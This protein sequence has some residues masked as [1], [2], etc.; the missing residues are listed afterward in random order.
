MELDRVLATTAMACCRLVGLARFSGVSVAMGR[1]SS[2]SLH[3]GVYEVYLVSTPDWATLPN[4]S[5]CLKLHSYYLS[6][7]GGMHR[8]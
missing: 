6:S 5:Q 2:T 1:L 4:L 7:G 8:N 3:D